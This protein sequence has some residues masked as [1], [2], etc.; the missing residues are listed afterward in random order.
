M[1]VPNLNCV[2][3][4][5]PHY[6]QSLLVRPLNQNLIK[7]SHLPIG[8]A[9]TQLVPVPL[10][11]S[12]L[13]AGVGY[14]AGCIKVNIKDNISSREQRHIC[15]QYTKQSQTQR[16]IYKLTHSPTQPHIELHRTKHRALHSQKQTPSQAD[17]II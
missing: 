6:Q 14:Q 3:T 8:H 16:A 15:Q 1:R 5:Q 7:K 11:A 17:Y 13:L 10:L 4:A 9:G 2:K 12:Q